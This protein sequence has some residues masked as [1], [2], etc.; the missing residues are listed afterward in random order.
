[1]E[2]VVVLIQNSTLPDDD[3]MGP[4]AHTRPCQV[5]PSTSHTCLPTKIVIK[6]QKEPGL[7]SLAIL[8]CTFFIYH[9]LLSYCLSLLF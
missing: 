2:V 6:L 9:L 8:I 4:M 3:F 5:L 1:M 7:K